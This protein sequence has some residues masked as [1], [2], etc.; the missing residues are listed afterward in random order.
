MRPDEVSFFHILS[1]STP[2]THD[3]YFDSHYYIFIFD[4]KKKG[5]LPLGN[6]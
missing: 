3:L 1:L 5:Q 2:Q 4:L 6:R